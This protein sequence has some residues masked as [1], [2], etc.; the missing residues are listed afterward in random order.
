MLYVGNLTLKKHMLF[1]VLGNY[2][3]LRIRSLCL[4]VFKKF[5]LS[6]LSLRKKKKE[7]LREVIADGMWYSKQRMDWLF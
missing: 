5:S 6:S 4:Y 3:S 2:F 7:K 1:S